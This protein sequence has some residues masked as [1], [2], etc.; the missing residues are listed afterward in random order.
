EVPAPGQT[1]I[2][3]SLAGEKVKKVTLLGYKGKIHWKATEDGLAITYPKNAQ[4]K[5]SAVFR[6]K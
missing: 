2:I 3:K 5:T 6:M 4:L 1:I